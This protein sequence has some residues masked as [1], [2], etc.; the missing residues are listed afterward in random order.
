MKGYALI[1]RYIFNLPHFFKNKCEKKRNIENTIELLY[2]DFDV[3]EAYGVD[4][5]LTSVSLVVSPKYRGRGIGEQL[6]QTREIVCHEFGIK[7]TSTSFTSDHSNRIA[8]N[9]GFKIDRI[10][11]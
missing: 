10:L 6:L 11:R 8:K 9:A 1:N 5:Y 3:C 4:K 7:L 2:K